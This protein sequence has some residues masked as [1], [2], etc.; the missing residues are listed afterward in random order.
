MVVAYSDCEDGMR[1]VKS[2]AQHLPFHTP[3]SKHLWAYYAPSTYYVRTQRSRDP[4][5]RSS[6]SSRPVK[7]LSE[8]WL[9]LLSR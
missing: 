1:H 4:G 2:S 8:Q 5:S 6:R 9:L 3:F 7:E